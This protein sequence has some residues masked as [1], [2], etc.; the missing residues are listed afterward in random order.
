MLPTIIY[1]S[2]TKGNMGDFK[3]VTC[4]LINQENKNIF[5]TIIK[6]KKEQRFLK[7]IIALQSLSL[8]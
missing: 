3:Q 8:L 4:M 7:I 1:T 5:F 6:K 2:V